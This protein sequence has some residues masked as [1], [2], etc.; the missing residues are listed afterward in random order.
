[1]IYCYSINMYKFRWTRFLS[2]LV[3]VLLGGQAVSYAQKLPVSKKVW[4]SL[5]RQ[6]AAGLISTQQLEHLI[7]TT[8]SSKTT[9]NITQVTVNVQRSRNQARKAAR[10]SSTVRLPWPPEQKIQELIRDEKNIFSALHKTWQIQEKFGDHQLFEVL[11]RNYYKQHFGTVT[12]HLQQF[13]T[14]ITEQHNP[15]LESR[16]L[17]RMRFLIENSN[18]LVQEIAPNVPRSAIRLRY[19]SNIAEITPNRF[20]PNMLVLSVERRMSPHPAKDFPLRHINGQ[21]VLK[22]GDSEFSVFAYAGPLEYLANLYQYLVN[23]KHSRAPMT[24]VFDEKNQALAVYNED[25]SLWIRITSHEFSHPDQL[26]LHLN[27]IRPVAFQNV[28]GNESHELVN[29]NLTI[30]L[31]TPA[32]LPQHGTQQFLYKYLLLNPVKHFQGSARVTIER[33]SIF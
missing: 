7:Q 29:I 26:H 3:C 18:L 20:N 2:L 24:M 32:D 28:Y 13:F 9:I 11:A 10:S 14:K 27:E 21:S 33:R 23:G 25:N 15:Q 31:T 16:V 30:P 8:A 17:K 6:Q 12:P 22:V 4:R 5:R 19:L 1:M